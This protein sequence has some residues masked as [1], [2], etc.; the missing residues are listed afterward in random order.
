M[1]VGVLKPKLSIQ[2]EAR[3]N[4]KEKDKNKT[5]TKKQQQQKKKKK[6]KC[7]PLAGAK[8]KKGKSEIWI[9]WEKTKNGW[10]GGGFGAPTLN[11]HVSHRMISTIFF[12]LYRILSSFSDRLR[13][14]QLI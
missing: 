10:R 11:D 7:D 9:F 8:N 2:N 5:T 14:N 1:R 3:K 6:K 13:I 4:E 12:Y